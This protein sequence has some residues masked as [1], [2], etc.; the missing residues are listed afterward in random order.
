M[1]KLWAAWR[2]KQSIAKRSKGKERKGK[3]RRG[4]KM[5]VSPASATRS[6]R[7]RWWWWWWRRQRWQHQRRSKR[8]RS[9]ASYPDRY[10]RVPAIRRVDPDPVLSDRHI[11]RVVESSAV[12]RK[13][14]S[15]DE[16]AG[17]PS[18]HWRASST[19]SRPFVVAENRRN[20][21]AP[22]LTLILTLTLTLT[23]TP[24]LTLTLTSKLWLKLRLF[25]WL[26]LRLWSRFWFQTVS[27]PELATYRGLTIHLVINVLF[28]L[29][30]RF[31]ASDKHQLLSRH[32]SLAISRFSFLS[33]ED[34]D[35][36][37]SMP[38]TLYRIN[39]PLALT[40]A[41]LCALIRSNIERNS[42]G[43]KPSCM[44]RSNA[45]FLSFVLIPRVR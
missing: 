39:E 32:A 27:V 38:S 9:A 7:Y 30:T 16:G 4:E 21:A 8:R 40:I 42:H 17:P 37:Y 15:L 2:W 41:R 20:V 18:R 13:A 29:L 43:N 36:D 6:N 25:L 22:A 10:N 19:R 35:V 34:N 1:I 12:R 44:R 45:L 31:L 28:P 26:W 24:T 3:E 11:D 33:I 23:P 5:I 14:N